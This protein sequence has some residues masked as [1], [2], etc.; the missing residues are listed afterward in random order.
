[1]MGFRGRRRRSDVS[2][3][4]GHGI[5]KTLHDLEP[6]I[7]AGFDVGTD[8]VERRN[9]HIG[10][11]D[12]RVNKIRTELGLAENAPDVVFEKGLSQGHDP[13]DGRR[14][15]RVDDNGASAIQSVGAFE[16]LVGVVEYEECLF[17]NRRQLFGEV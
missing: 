17:A 14:A 10:P 7:G 9:A 12:D 2:E 4:F 11:F 3:T 5:S 15:R 8:R 6:G 1:M 13:S 16:V